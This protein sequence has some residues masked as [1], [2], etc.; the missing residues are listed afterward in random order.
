MD[1]VLLKPGNVDLET[2]YLSLIDGEV[3]ASGE[4]LSGAVELVS[5]NYG[6]AQAMTTDVSNQ[7]RT[8][9]RPNLNDITIVKYLDVAS[10]ILYRHCL[11][12]T[13]IDDGSEDEPTKIFMC[14]NANQDGDDNIIGSIMT[15][16]L[17]NCMISSVQAQSHPNDMATEQFTLNFTDIEWSATHQGV[18]AQ[19]SGQLAYRWS[20]ARNRQTV[21][22]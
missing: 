10:P 12:A 15:I 9:G 22:S 13:P 4:D 8:T 6:M 19:V 11:S 3:Q 20:V 1:L 2:D 7:A 16:S 17:W 21:V 5:C 14:R 18:D